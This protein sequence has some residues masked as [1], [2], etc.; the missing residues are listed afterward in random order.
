[1][2][3][4]VYGTALGAALGNVDTVVLSTDHPSAHGLLRVRVTSAEGR[5]VRAEPLTGLVHRGVEKLF[6]ARDYRQILML[7]DRHDW[8]GA[9][10]SEVALALAAES[11]LGIVVPERA[12]WIRTACVELTRLTSHLAFLGTFPTAAGIALDLRAEREQL[13]HLFD[14]AWGSRL[15]VMANRIGGLVHD[16]PRGWYDAVLLATDRVAGRLPELDEV[17]AG[18]DLHG[19]GVISR[20]AAAAYG[21]SGPV[22]RASG[23]DLDLRRDA[24]HLGYG[25][26]FDGLGV[27]VVT[28]SAGDVP[29]RLRVASAECALSVDIV[30]YAVERLRSATGPIDVRLPK[31]VRLPEGEFYAAVEGPSGMSGFYLVSRGDRVPWRVRMRTASFAHAAVSEVALVGARL[32]E[33]EPILASLF[34]LSGDIE[35]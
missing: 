15:H 35:R 32:E 16:V 29:A 7:T 12:T 3:E 24:P 13:H 17:I 23:L 25:E 22:G 14:L 6:E 11:A 33:V 9:F 8:L 26:V 30:R 19:V 21:A 1:M 27:P 20:E 4:A 31:V 34:L 10:S 2:T 5:V 28:Q 18:L